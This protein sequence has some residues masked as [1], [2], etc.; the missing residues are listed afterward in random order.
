MWKSPKEGAA[1]IQ[2]AKVLK[3]KAE[4]TVTR[5]ENPSST[6]RARTLGYKAKQGIMV[7][8]VRVL[9]GGRKIPKVKGGRR[10]ARAGCFFTLNKSKQQLAEE[11]AQTKFRNMEVL[12]SYW[13]GG[14]GM[15]EWFEVIMADRT[16]PSVLADKNLKWL[17][18]GRGRAFRGL[19]S[20][21]RKA[22]G[23]LNKSRKQ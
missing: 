11:K 6:A 23:L 13:A 2:K 1:G 8:R 22:R 18:S 9:K 16:H 19:T 15:Y 12:N 21:G 17:S 4:P 14:D 5:V 7:A 20:S 10:P 3:W